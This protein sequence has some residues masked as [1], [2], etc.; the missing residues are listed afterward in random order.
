MSTFR[1]CYGSLANDLDIGSAARSAR[2]VD[3]AA[4]VSA[5]L[6]GHGRRILIPCMWSMA[7]AACVC[8]QPYG[9]VYG[10]LACELRVAAAGFD[11]TAVWTCA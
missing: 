7:P 10:Q 6:C 8:V 11:P 2:G 5:G 1:L 3:V 9:A 4:H